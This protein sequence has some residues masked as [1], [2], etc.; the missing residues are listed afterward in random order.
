MENWRITKILRRVEDN[1][2]TVEEGKK[3]A[4]DFALLGL[5]TEAEKTSL[6]TTLNSM[7][8]EVVE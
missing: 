6:M 4:L 1:S 3:Y 7:V 8:E 2:L 5:I